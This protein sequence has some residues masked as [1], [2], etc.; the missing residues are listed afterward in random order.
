V[1][2]KQY[3]D[4]RTKLSHPGGAA[5]LAMS[6]GKSI[7]GQ[8]WYNQSA[9]RAV[10]QVSES[11]SITL[12]LAERVVHQAIGR[13]IRHKNDWGAIMLLD[14]RF[15]NEKHKCQLSRWVRPRHRGYRYFVDAMVN[16]RYFVS[17]ALQD[18]I[19]TA[20]PPMLEHSLPKPIS[21]LT[22][23][24]RSESSGNA[25]S[26]GKEAVVM[27]S[28]IPTQPD[29][30]S[31][32]NPALLM[33]Q[34][35]IMHQKV[36]VTDDVDD[37]NI[38]NHFKRV[39]SSQSQPSIAR[40]ASFPVKA[41]EKNELPTVNSIFDRKFRSITST[42]TTAAS[43]LETATM[44][45]PVIQYERQQRH[46]QSSKQPSKFRLGSLMDLT[47]MSDIES[48]TQSKPKPALP[49]SFLSQAPANEV[50]APVKSLAEQGM[51][52]QLG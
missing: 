27:D 37:L 8:D 11:M 45:R 15:I 18:P 47:A 31:F 35:A 22:S 25:M 41:V 4:E 48:S 23:M 10:N 28:D 14:D 16:F 9:V 6:R 39:T 26:F 2:K 13:V 29:G 17:A 51:I 33:S 34:K 44:T 5:N 38:E 36:H 30:T 12:P 42:S 24:P 19:L 50:N 3:L 32:I 49:M 43:K 7:N 20:P 21:R 52:P 46:E 40:L 1:L